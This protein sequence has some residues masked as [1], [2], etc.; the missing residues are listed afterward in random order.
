MMSDRSVFAYIGVLV[1]SF[2]MAAWAELRFE[3]HCSE[4]VPAPSSRWNPD[5]GQTV[6][7]PIHGEAAGELYVSREQWQR[8]ARSWK[9]TLLLTGL[10]WAVVLGGALLRLRR[11]STGLP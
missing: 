5:T 7:L 11:M 3:L 9:T 4:L 6:S 10:L 2:A 8:I 1:L